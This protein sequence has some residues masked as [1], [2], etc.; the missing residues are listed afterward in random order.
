[1]HNKGENFLN[2]C[3]QGIKKKTKKTLPNPGLNVDIFRTLML[4]FGV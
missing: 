3:E 1:M 4:L 2:M